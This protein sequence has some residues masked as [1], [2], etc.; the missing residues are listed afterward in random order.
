MKRSFYLLILIFLVFFAISFLT[1]ILG[2]I[3]PNV[4]DSFALSG[5]MTGMLPFSFFI[6]YA[7]MSIPSGMFVQKYGE[8]KSLILAWIL[9]FAGALIF[10]SF[11]KFPVFLGSLFLIGSGMALLQVALYPLLRVVGGEEHF[12]FNSV[13]AQLVF[14]AA[15]FLSPFVYSY[16]VT[17][18][19]DPASEGGFVINL[20]SKLTPLD[21][22]WVSIYLVFSAV[23]LLM[24]V[25]IL[26]TKFPPVVR[27]EDEVVGAWET[28]LQLF[29]NRTVILFFLGIFAYVGAEQ[30]IANWI[31]E[32]LRTYHGLTPEVEGARTVGLFWGMM[33]VGCFL[34]LGLLKLMDSK[35]VLGI[36]TTAALI[37]LTFTLFG[38]VKF[39]LFGFAALGFCLSVMYAIIFSLALNSVTKYH[40]SFAGILCTAIAGGAIFSLLIGK[41]KD[42]IG[43]QLGMILLYLPLAYIL[44]IALWAKPIVRNATIGKA[45]DKE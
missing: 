25:I 10:S 17:N 34:G 35:L 45:G 30:G 20:I 33:T 22:P 1:N 14:G 4:T 2:S 37:I 9:A 7:I 8:K 23:S 28:H 36:F 39:A 24:L 31:S 43:L 19:G 15:S 21:L 29:K 5:T 32:F 11:P 27:K 18:L 16:L 13:I 44:S 26:S 42:M 12:A 40:G 3:N 6:A 38:S 41:L